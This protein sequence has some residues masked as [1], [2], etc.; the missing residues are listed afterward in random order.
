MSEK[1]NNTENDALG[2]VDIALRKTV[3]R[4]LLVFAVATGMAWLGKIDAD[5]WSMIAMIYIGSQSVID[6]ATKW[7]YG[8]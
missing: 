5:A 4:K 8:K 7:K 6:A 2:I 3:S 1:V